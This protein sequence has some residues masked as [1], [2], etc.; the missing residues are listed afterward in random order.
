MK[1][2][3][4]IL[5]LGDSAVFMQNIR[6]LISSDDVE[7]H[8][9]LCIEDAIVSLT[10]NE[11][12][13]AILD[14]Q[15]AGS[16][17]FELT[18]LNG[19][20]N[21]EKLPILYLTDL[22]NI[23]SIEHH[24]NK[25]DT[26]DYIF[27]PLNPHILRS[28]VNMFVELARLRTSAEAARVAKSQF[29]TN[30]SHEFRTPLSAVM[31]FADLMARGEVPENEIFD[32]AASVRRNG[33][34]LL[35]LI[36]NILDLSKL[37]SN[38]LE[39]EMQNYPLIEVIKDI[40]STLSLKARE[41]GIELS[42]NKSTC[43]KQGY[44]FDPVR[45]K[46]VLLNIIGNAIK[47]SHKGEV[48]VNIDIN[49][50]SST[51]D[52]LRVIVKNDGI[53]FSEEQASRLFQPFGQ[54]DASVKREFG[55]SGLGLVISRQLTR[56]MGGDVVILKSEIGVGTEIEITAVLERSKRSTMEPIALR[57]TSFET[58]QLT[59]T[60]PGKHILLVDDAKDNLILLEM[61]LRGTETCLTIASNGLEAY[62]LCKNNKYD[63]ILMDIQMPK[64]DGREATAAIRLLGQKMP[65]IA[66][67]A[68]ASK[69]EYLKCREAGCNDSLIKPFSKNNLM[70]ALHHYFENVD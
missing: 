1:A 7:I 22:K 3:T 37:E 55:G 24:Y 9:C 11:Y 35:R 61:F 63:M 23:S 16:E 62:E 60:F 57:K 33:K 12:S 15:M 50:I 30:M 64:M 46:Q 28:K 51:H 25:S 17:D 39:M 65:I 31:G 44:V 68:H 66:L 56:A 21:N 32:C 70:K 4:K 34:L 27:K 58:D 29:L 26:I 45:I 53:G 14:L 38:Q 67:T 10:L 19:Y 42:F 8:S 69:Q 54:A 52:L 18:K 48:L 6:D 49:P 47:F 40:E 5:L 59:K 41:K 20:N 2:K 36:D 13:L 43:D